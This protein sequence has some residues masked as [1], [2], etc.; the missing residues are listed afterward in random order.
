MKFIRPTAVTDAVLISSTVPETDY[1]AW[2]AATAYAGGDRVIRAA[3]HK[4]FERV[5]AGTT[6]TA[7]E[8]DG[9]NWLEVGPTNRWRMFDQKL[10]TVTTRVDSITVVLTPGRINGLA[11]LGVD[12]STVTVDLTVDEGSGPVSVYSASLDLDSGVQVGNW[13]EYF[14]EPIYTQD[15]VVITDLLD[16]SLLDVPAYADGVLTVTLARAGGDVSCGLMVVGL[17]TELG[18]TLYPANVSIR[19][20]S[21]K[22]AD[23]FGNYALVQRDY[24]KRMSAEVLVDSS[25]ADQVVRNISRYRATNVVWIG[26]KKYGSLIVYGFVSDWKLVFENARISK[27]SLEVEGMT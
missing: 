26:S 24:S 11:L 3:L 5:V 9:S 13:Y 16:A 14:Y 1:P 8:A 23:D 22:E 18:D 7:P 17:V 12:A 2:S 15:S 25:K 19:D 10:G 27:F 6:A 20:Y 4:V 21:R